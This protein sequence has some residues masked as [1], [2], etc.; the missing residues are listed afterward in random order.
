MSEC[1]KVGE[2]GGAGKAR[3]VERG[4]SAAVETWR[5]S[6]TFVAGVAWWMSRTCGSFSGVDE[7][8]L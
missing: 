1:G 4:Y 7:P 5:L 6:G 8:K 2:V 3:W